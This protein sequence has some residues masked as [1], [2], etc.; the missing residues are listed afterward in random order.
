[1]NARRTLV[2]GVAAVVMVTGC[3]SPEDTA[4]MASGTV[5]ATEARLG[6]PVGGRLLDVAVREGQ[7]VSV[8]TV[9]ATLDRAE[10]E[11]RREQADAQL[12]VARAA[13]LELE[14][15]FR[16]EEIA[17]ARSGSNAATSRLVDAEQSFAR[18]RTL[19]EGGAVSQEVLDRAQMAL[20]IARSEKARADDQLR[21]MEAGP[22]PERIEAQRAQV[23]QAE[24]AVRALDV[25]LT[26][27]TLVATFDGLV[28]T[29]HREPGEIVAPGAAVVTVMSPTDRWVRIYVPENRLGG[30]HVG[31]SAEISSDTDPDK[32]YTGTVTYIASEAEFTPKTVQT[33]E[34]RVKLVYQVKVRITGDPTLE[35]KPGMPADVRLVLTSS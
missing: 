35:L 1:M 28:T 6:F 16:A 29:R 21:L 34:E 12:G 18:T 14:R 31:T 30:L 10:L 33:T 3:R 27:L 9:L 13:L 19:R 8:G 17:Q 23:R 26:N 20:D 7:A 4:I 25:M 32:R 24:A 2:A 11:A 22:R 5:E 15:G